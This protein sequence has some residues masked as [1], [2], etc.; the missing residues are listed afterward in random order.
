MSEHDPTAPWPEQAD[1]LVSAR[2]D[3]EAT[4]EEA[5]R[6][7]AD[8]VL[9]ARLQQFRA[10]RASIA[11]P[12][13]L[14]DADRERL[15]RRALDAFDTPTATSPWPTPTPS[16]T[17]ADPPAPAAAVVDLSA[18]RRR[19]RLAGALPAAAAIAALVLGGLALLVASQDD[20]EQFRAVGS[21]IESQQRSDTADGA[22]AAAPETPAF[23]DDEESSAVAEAGS[24][25]SAT[26]E[27]P[28]TTGG[29]APTELGDLGEVDDPADLRAPAL[30]ALARSAA[31]EADPGDAAPTT[32]APPSATVTSTRPGGPVCDPLAAGSVD[33]ASLVGEGTATVDGAP[34]VVLVVSRGTE[35]VVVVVDATTC[36][37]LA[38]G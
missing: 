5:A 23:E 9:R 37:V 6:V 1:E 31:A 30:D 24:A 33:P 15:L 11:V 38:R 28:T 34:V 3:G 25:D 36:G 20:E 8:P 18:R 16:P 32:T 13:T 19:R 10:Q 29:A 2:L 17:T 4:P 12:T 21:G 7:E 22:D 26:G 14:S 27:A 35:R